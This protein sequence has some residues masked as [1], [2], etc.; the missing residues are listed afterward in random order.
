M[1]LSLARSIQ[2]ANSCFWAAHIASS[3]LQIPEPLGSGISKV[4]IE[5]WAHALAKKEVVGTS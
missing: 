3:V 2:F 4:V 1:A 5:G